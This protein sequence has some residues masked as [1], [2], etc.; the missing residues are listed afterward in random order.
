MP[1]VVTTAIGTSSSAGALIVEPD[2]DLVVAGTADEG[3]G[4]HFLVG[5]YTAAGALDSSFNELGSLPGVLVVPM[6]TESGAFA[7]VRQPDG[8]VVAA[9][10][11]EDGTPKVALARFRT[12]GTL[13]AG[14]NSVGTPPGVLLDDLGGSADTRARGLVLQPDG[15]AVVTGQVLDGGVIKMMVARYTPG[16]A[17]DLTFNV[18][19]PEQGA[20]FTPIG[21]AQGVANAAALQPDGK[22]VAIGNATDGT[23]TKFALARYDLGDGAAAQADMS[24]AASASPVSSEP[25]QTVTYTFTVTNNGP[26]AAPATVSAPLPGSQTFAAAEG[27][28][29]SS[30]STP[31]VGSSGSVI[32]TLPTL[33]SGGTAVVTVDAV[34]AI[35]SAD[36]LTATVSTVA[37]DPEEAN[38]TASATVNVT[39]PAAPTP[40]PAP[41][42][43]VADL[44]VVA[45]ADKF[46]AVKGDPIGFTVRVLN[47]GPNAAGAVLS[48]ELD[49]KFAFISASGGE[50]TV[51]RGGTSGTIVCRLSSLGSGSEASFRILVH[52]R[53]VGPAALTAQVSPV[54]P[55]TDP[56]PGGNS[57]Q[58]NVT[59]RRN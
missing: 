37:D 40:P 44:S 53:R 43:Q 3:A 57:A 28:S 2:G 4:P 27:P 11:A 5:R 23:E 1:G 50:C 38:N 48:I 45:S 31:P 19:G 35:P 30:C 24:L 25:D 12:D 42:A 47:H 17:R 26:D 56:N 7:L 39:A 32:C 55:A 51:P 9:G 10:Y 54:A 21:T 49:R 41:P 33:P 59:T 14:Y 18:A 46:R 13:D 29:G 6:G 58:A 16:G 15:K 22:L 36:T 52:P 34:M 20:V 8:K